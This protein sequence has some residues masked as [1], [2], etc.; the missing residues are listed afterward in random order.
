MILLCSSLSGHSFICLIISLVDAESPVQPIFRSKS[1]LF[2]GVMF[3]FGQ[4]S[5]TISFIVFELTCS[6]NHSL[7]NGVYDITFP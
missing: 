2:N 6:S 3:R 1:M 7:L 5:C 4:P